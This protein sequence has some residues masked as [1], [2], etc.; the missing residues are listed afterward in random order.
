MKDKDSNKWLKYLLVILLVILI[1]S[2]FIFLFGFERD[3]EEESPNID[4]EL[5]NQLYSYLPTNPMSYQTVYTGHYIRLT[6]I[7]NTIISSVIYDYIK[8]YEPDVIEE[9]SLEEFETNNLIHDTAQVVNPLCKIKVEE[10]LK[11]YPQIFGSS[12]ELDIANFRYDYSTLA[13]V[14]ANQTYYYFYT[15]TPLS[16]SSNEVVYKDIIR[17]ALTDNNTT[18]E[19]YDYYLK[20]DLNTNSCY[21][22]ERKNNLNNQ[23]TYSSNF[24]IAN[25]TNNL[26]TYKHTYKYEDGHYYWYS[27]ELV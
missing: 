16:N 9:T 10:F 5:I 21:N 11:V 23:I 2:L 18:I 14:D 24:D 26:V 4:E 15:T 6:N 7:D 19:I 3:N 1:V 20:C 8:E 27:S 13:V 22:D 17:Y 12:N 25:Y